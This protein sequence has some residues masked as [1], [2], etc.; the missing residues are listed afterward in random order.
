MHEKLGETEK[1]EQCYIKAAGINRLDSGI[2]VNLGSLYIRQGRY[3]EAKRH[4]LKAVR[5]APSNIMGWTG[6]RQLALLRG[7]LS[8]FTRSTLAVLPRL[9]DEVL[10]CSIEILY[11][12]NQISRAEALLFQ[13]D[14]MGKDGDLLDVQRLLIYRRKGINQGR[15]VAIYKRL[16][17]MSDPQDQVLKAG[18]VF[19]VEWFIQFCNQICGKD[20]KAR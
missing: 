9:S 18:S 17:G 6:I 4:F 1:A 10:A 19:S 13:A 7:D 11:E 8:T 2:H 20:E 3:E 12:L 16:S 14:R 5:L 15:V